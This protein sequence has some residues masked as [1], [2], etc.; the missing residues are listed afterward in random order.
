MYAVLPNPHK[1]AALHKKS[2]QALI[3]QGEYC[4]AVRQYFLLINIEFDENAHVIPLN[5]RILPVLQLRIF[6]ILHYW[7][8]A[9]PLK[10]PRNRAQRGRGEWIKSEITL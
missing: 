10:K 4:F 6:L 5:L 1:N 9:R 8:L 2:C 3:F 7:S